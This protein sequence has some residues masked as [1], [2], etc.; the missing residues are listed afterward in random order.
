MATALGAFRGIS[1]NSVPF[2]SVT[3]KAKLRRKTPL[4]PFSKRIRIP[5]SP[6]AFICTN[7]AHDFAVRVPLALVH[8]FSVDS[9]RRPD[10]GVAHEFLLHFH[11]SSSLVEQSPK[12]VPECMPADAS[13]SDQASEIASPQ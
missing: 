11:W 13:E 12:G 2:L 1:K 3:W 9:H 5:P 4:F 8:S 6:P 10:I 7:K